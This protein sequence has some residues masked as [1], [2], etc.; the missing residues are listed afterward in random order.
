MK[1]S[2][3]QV[4]ENTESNFSEHPETQLFGEFDYEA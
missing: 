3:A 1:K 2:L 4:T